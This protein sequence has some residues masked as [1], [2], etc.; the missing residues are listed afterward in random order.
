MKWQSIFSIIGFM[1]VV[2]GFMMLFPAGLDYIDGNVKSAKIFSVTAALTVAAGSVLLLSTERNQSVLK[3]KEMF[4]TTTLIWVFYIFFCSLPYFFSFYGLGFARSIFE[5]V[6]GLTTTGATIFSNL[7]SLPE[8]VL[9]WR[10]LTHWM[11]GLGILVVAILIL[12]TLRTGGMQLFNIEVSGESNR[13]APTIFQNVFSILIYF[14]VFTVVAVICLKL[15]GMN[16]FDAV[17]HAM[18]VVATG[19]FSTHDSSIA[20][21]HSPLIEWVLSLFMFW[22]GLPLMFSIYLFHGSLETIRKNDQIRLYFFSFIGFVLFMGTLRWVAVSFNNDSLENILRTTVFSVASI[23]TSTGF[24]LDNYQLWGSWAMAFFM[25]L[26]LPGG[27]TGSTTG[28]IKMFRLS[29]LFKI[30]H[31]KLKSTARPHG[32]FVP[33]YGDKA[34][35]EDVVFGVLTYIGLYFVSLFVGTLVLSLFQLD[36]VS[37]FSGALSALSNIGPALGEHIGPDKTFA[38]LPSGALYVLS[39]LM[40]LGRLE[41]VAIL[42]LVLPFFWKKNI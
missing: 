11:G 36:F 23:L 30:I 14:F 32:I 34:I 22:G 39:F 37:A 18:S 27:C 20:Y 19:G 6:S 42:I 40:L 25:V 10:S 1:V 12:P 9:L 21:F 16:W 15:A 8:G 4:V 2:C 33:R 28:G 41:F 7:D 3:T 35:E 17:N 24:T 5:S 31:A 13:D 29:V 38:F 26:M